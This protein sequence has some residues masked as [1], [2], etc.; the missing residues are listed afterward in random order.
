MP[1]EMT[2]DSS[3]EL[4]ANRDK[5]PSSV[6]DAP[7]YWSRR[8]LRAASEKAARS[9]SAVRAS[10]QAKPT[11]AERN[12]ARRLAT[13]GRAP[14]AA[15]R[16]VLPPQPRKKKQNPLAVIFT[17]LIVPG[18]IASA[19]LPAYAFTSA[20]ADH[21]AE[22]EQEAATADA[23]AKPDQE[24]VVAASAV[25]LDVSRDTITATTEEELQA[26]V[27]AAQEAAAAA[28]TLASYNSGPRA[29]GDDYP[30][31]SAG[32]SLSP[33][34]YYYRQCVDFV[35]WRLN[36]DA[37]STKAPF[38]FVW[39]NL[40]PGHGSAYAWKSAWEAHGWKTSA[41]PVV[42]A[43]AWFNG[44]HVAYVRDI[45]GGSVVIEEYNGISSRSYATRTI[46][47]GSVARFLYPPPR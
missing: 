44:N 40:T 35:A 24:L 28:A 25:S 23:S 38:K 15:I 31:R 16:E 8:E 10:R 33:L 36:R 7:Q 29:P 19:S 20:G 4:L 12:T 22:I 34:N 6:P 42:G 47:I 2:T 9:Q 13:E 27:V 37:G 45:K 39:S 5:S 41:K 3:A 46:P 14:G 1:D 30:W 18:F 32:N 11:R 26:Q 17:L 43:V 21:Q